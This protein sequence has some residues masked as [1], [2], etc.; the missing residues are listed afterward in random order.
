[1][2][3]E[4]VNEK[5]NHKQN[6]PIFL[7]SQRNKYIPTFKSHYSIIKIK[8]IA[9]KKEKNYYLSPNKQRHHRT[10]DH[11]RRRRARRTPSFPPPH[12]CTPNPGASLTTPGTAPRSASTS[13]GPEKPLVRYNLSSSGENLT[14][15]TR[16]AVPP[17]GGRRTRRRPPS[18]GSRRYAARAALT[19]SPLE[20]SPWRTKEEEFLFP[21]VGETHSDGTCLID[22][23]W[24][25]RAS[26]ETAIATWQHLVGCW[27]L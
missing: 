12:S 16:S 13:P 23:C 25:E 21:L 2:W 14:Y 8:K 24:T 19:P 6:P 3:G 7:S 20:A 15:F 4:N 17:P 9:F 22:F 11:P 26:T 5:I 10:G 1:M 27:S 18:S